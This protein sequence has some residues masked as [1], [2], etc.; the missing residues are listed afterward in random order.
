MQVFISWSGV[1]SKEV[2]V[3][4]ADWLSQVIQAVDP[5]I[6]SD[7][8]KGA[9]WSPEIAG[10]LEESKVGIVCL[11]KENLDNRWIS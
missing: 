6:S 3:A 8:D 9:R 10:R 4:I 5:W 2:A 11:T 7:I 1:R